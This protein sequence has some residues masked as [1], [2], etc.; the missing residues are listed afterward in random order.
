MP[1]QSPKPTLV[2]YGA[3]SYTARQ[4]LTY[5]ESHPE[6]SAFA[7]ILSG[8]NAGRLNSVN[9]RL[10]TSKE[11][12]V[13]DLGDEEAVKALVN[14]GDVVMNL[15]GP[16]R[17]HNGEA[18]VKA[19]AESG[20]HYVDLC[21]EADWL[22]RT[23]IPKYHGLA[24]S[25][26]A[27]IIP[28]SGFDS[29][30][31]DLSVYVSLKTLQTA[32]PGLTLADSTSFFQV[33]ATMS[34]GTVQSMVSV[35]E[36]PPDQRRSGEYA[37]CPGV[38]SPKPAAP[39]L[40]YFLPSP[41]LSSPRWA[42]FFFMFP[43]N[44]TIVRRSQYLSALTPARTSSTESDE[45]IHGEGMGYAEGL[46][47]G[48]GRLGSGL[49]S[50]GFFLFFGLFY[51]SKTLRNLFLRFLPKAGE[52]SSLEE[53]EKG[54]YTVTNVSTSKP[55]PFGETV[56]VVTKFEGDGDP[57]YLNT[58]Y[59]LVE[60]ALSLVLPP[61]QGTSLPPLA[62]QGGVLTPSTG[63]GGVLVERLKLCG[64]VRIS[65]EIVYSEK[66]KKTI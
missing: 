43:F 63:L 29:V 28:A 60:S 55:L 21:G 8:R 54:H 66:D 22:A 32:H 14:R 19:C 45:P 48:A 52:G 1:Q 12:V 36:L 33:K 10:K 15:A 44:R 59:M 30:P 58:C 24:A 2:V 65:S 50:F 17:W 26:G 27:K 18:L 3:T 11:I 6:S 23:V 4:L 16:Y 46:D 56:Q 35:A 42:S 64:M 49:A 5:L 34:G 25:T 38:K 61:P 51:T 7:F 62:K 40:T 47:I 53:L 9:A 57:G 41:P 37:L 20:K 39:S 31:S 13:C